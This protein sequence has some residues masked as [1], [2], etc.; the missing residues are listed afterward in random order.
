VLGDLWRIGDG[1]LTMARFLAQLCDGRAQLFEELLFIVGH[2]DL[3]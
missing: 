3:E 1:V 2:Q